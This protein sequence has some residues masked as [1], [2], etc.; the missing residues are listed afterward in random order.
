[1]S[2]KLLSKGG[3]GCIF[4]PGITCKGYSK[5]DK[6][7]VTKLQK[8]DFNA[9]N[10]IIIGNLIKKIKNYKNY[11]LPVVNSCPVN[12]RK[13]NNPELKKCDIISSN[14]NFDY[15][16][17]DIPFVKN[18]D[19]MDV[20]TDPN[21]SHKERVAFILH[22]YRQLLK[23][24]QLLSN[25]GVAHFDLKLDNILFDKKT[26]LPYI[27][28]FGISIPM[29]TIT[30][31]N[32][33]EYFYTFAPEYYVWCLDII[34]IN[35]LLYETSKPLSLEN[36]NYIVD[37]YIEYNRGLSIYSEEFKNL[38]KDACIK[39][40]SQFIGV[41]KNKVI[42]YYMN[43]YKTWD[44]YS[45]SIIY[46]KILST[47]LS[48]SDKSINNSYIISLAEILTLNISPNPEKRLSIQQTR[49][50]FNNF[51][52]KAD[53]IENYRHFIYSFNFNNPSTI[54]QLKQDNAYLKFTKNKYKY[55]N[56][57]IA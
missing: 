46:L 12:I 42:Q 15:I 9:N 29:N 47:F 3:F 33:R 27:I 28:D 49:E 34:V 11:F 30:Q 23:A 39:Q 16:V 35:Y 40:L 14:K 1:M 44:N 25:V 41:D 38:F 2:S 13:M 7:H 20:L 24:L 32:I 43:H 5:K 55:S 37:L 10:E 6:K 45:L 52:L 53:N 56:V 51:I 26:Q 19:F 4:Y 54:K 21:T 36:I 50:K 17:M 22:S 48:K 31:Q 8:R 18:V 57:M